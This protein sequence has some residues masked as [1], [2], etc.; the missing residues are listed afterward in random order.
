MLRHAILNFLYE[1]IWKLLLVKLSI[2][3]VKVLING[4]IYF[5]FVVLTE[6]YKSLQHRIL[7]G[8]QLRLKLKARTRNTIL[9]QIMTE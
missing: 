9:F 4:L 3:V 5:I 1:L 6:F 8:G 7:K 2:V